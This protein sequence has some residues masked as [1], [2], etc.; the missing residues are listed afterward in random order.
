MDRAQSDWNRVKE[1]FQ[2]ALELDPGRRAAFL[3]Q[4][5]SDRATRDQVEKLLRNYEEAGGFFD[6]P[7][8]NRVSEGM[9]AER[10][11]H[12]EM[13]YGAVPGLDSV[14]ADEPM[15]GRRLGAY[16]LRR[17][18]GQGGMAA[19]FLATRDDEAYQKEVAI[20]LVQPGRESRELLDRFRNER[21]TLADLDHPNI[22][23]L[24]DGGSTPEGLPFLVMDYVEG[25]PIDE[26]CD[27]HKLSVDKRL[28]LFM[29]VCDAVQYAHDKAVVHRDLKPS[30]ILVT[31]DGTPKV[32]DF[33]IAKVLDPS[34]VYDALLHTQTGVRCMTPA[35]ASPEQMR[36]KAITPA[37]DVYSLGVV[38]YELLSGH[39]PYKLKEDTPVE[40]ERA[41]CET[42]P[43]PPSTAVSRIESVAGSERPPTRETPRTVS[44][45]REATPE[46]LRRRLRGDLDN[47]VLKALQKDPERRYHTV[48]E[49]SEDVGR[50]LQNKPVRARRTR[51]TYRA[52][53][54]VWRH[55]FEAATTLFALLVFVA[56]VLF[57][58]DPLGLR[59]RILGKASSR[60][61]KIV[62]SGAAFASPKL[63]PV[64]IRPA[65]T[66]ESLLKLALPN[67]LIT[68]VKSLSPPS[69]DSPDSDI[70]T[71]LPPFCRVQG[72][73]R[74]TKGSN[75]RFEVWMPSSGWN[76][77]FRAVGND[78]F[79]G[80]INRDD[81]RPAVIRG[82][83]TAST[84]TGHRASSV[85]SEWALGH[86][87]K[88]VDFGYRAIHEMTLRSKEIIHAFYGQFPNWSYFE[89][90]STG[91]R[92]GLMEAQRFPDDY[93]GI[94]AGAP[95]F[96]LTREIPEGLYNTAADPSGYIPERKIP[97]IRAAVLSA[98]DELDGLKDGMLSDPRGCRFDP[99]VLA[100]HAGDSDN[101]LTPPQVAQLQK[102]YQG[103]RSETGEQLALGY[104]PGGEEGESGWKSWITGSARGRGAN[105]MFGLGLLRN[106]VFGDPEWDFRTIKP[107][108]AMRIAD[109]RIGRIVNST[110]PDLRTF[111]LHGGKLVLYH[112]WSDPIMP[113]T[114][115]VRYF[116]TVS[117]TM[118]PT[119]KDEF[120]RLYMVPGL[121]HCLSGPG[122]NY[123]GQEDLSVL[124]VDPQKLT[125]PLDP[126]H[127]I[128][129]AL[130][131]WVEQGVAP[132]P[133]IATKFVNDLDPGA[134]VQMTRPICPYP[135]IAA[136]KGSGDTN[137]SAN[138]SCTT[139]TS[140]R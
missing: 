100:C 49:F 87:E 61:Q 37:T 17:R 47:I 44:E 52:Y 68:S 98:C 104:L 51:L 69:E 92:Q 1:L 25:H 73:I 108:Q 70:M 85:D 20:K 110:D 78:G 130:E 113:G 75:I 6:D 82:Y 38:L 118:G 43:E 112:G 95:L 18:I 21:Q 71:G 16:K 111:K 76:G 136:Y 119:T 133:I 77:R 53:K 131:Q 135:Q 2:T 59:D 89:G 115:A 102:M 114:T 66:C 67:T 57:V 84:D 23:K 105:Y 138:F 62:M 132:G 127:N 97:A 34:S 46:K 140:R 8:V 117:S 12:S 45:D 126:E 58:Y 14:E 80:S 31:Q 50:H 64:S 5:C 28:E 32:L 123:F 90:C 60:G 116:D 103:L 109:D 27:K 106:L 42:D 93:Q 121:H 54:F 86:P 56:A 129:S 36:G 19:V 79:G 74:P 10:L 91:G 11:L 124:G 24:L 15:S 128:S 139:P 9:T 107:E 41:I 33:G 65:V 4:D 13:A 7:I 26:Y 94:L 22:V 30:N 72:E 55:R 63:S 134:G 101:C 29:R 96:S 137:D 39:R 88:I 125:T 3:D 81:M 40:I 99:S 48:E 120:V 35:Y 122:P 83:A